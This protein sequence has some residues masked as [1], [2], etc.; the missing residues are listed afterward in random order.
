PMP[1][2]VSDHGP[3][4]FFRRPP[5]SSASEISLS[6][7]LQHRSW[8]PVFLGSE[9]GLGV[10]VCSCAKGPFSRKNLARAMRTR[11]PY[12]A[13]GLS[14]CQFLHFAFGRATG[15]RAFLL[16]LFGLLLLAGGATG[17]LTIFLAQALGICHECCDCPLL[18][19][20]PDLQVCCVV[21]A[22]TRFCVLSFPA[23][24]RWA[25]RR[26]RFAATAL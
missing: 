9:D 2:A 10:V 26:R 12:L 22:G 13:F 19:D 11:A 15:N 16:W 21:P 24:T 25:N 14:A 8:L 20:S 4:V 18:F 5:G 17:F 1:R 23:L 7:D 6:M 3:R